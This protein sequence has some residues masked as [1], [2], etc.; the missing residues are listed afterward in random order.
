MPVTRLPVR[1][2]TRSALRYPLSP[3]YSGA[4]V[5]AGGIITAN[6]QVWLRKSTASGASWPD[7]SGNALNMTLTGSPTIGATSVTFNG[8]SQ[9]GVAAGLGSCSTLYLRMRQVSWTS[10][11]VVAGGPIAAQ[12]NLRQTAGTPTL[13]GYDSDATPYVSNGDATIGVMVSLCLVNSGAGEM[14]LNID[15]AEVSFSGSV[16]GAFSALSLGGSTAGTL[17]SNIEVVEAV[18]YTTA[19]G[20]GE[21]AQM[22]DYLDTL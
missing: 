5:P 20:S 13:E 21:R 19:H 6:R 8:T 7:A 2:A 4:S 15:G 22:I 18:A 9:Y 10:G 3:V 1:L 11:R 17:F 16:G 14:V 12:L